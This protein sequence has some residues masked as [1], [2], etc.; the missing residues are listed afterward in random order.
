MINDNSGLLTASSRPASPAPGGIESNF[1]GLELE[2][3]SITDIGKFLRH[4]G[5]TIGWGSELTYLPDRN[6]TAS[7]LVSQPT[8]TGASALEDSGSIAISK[9]IWSTVQQYPS[10]GSAV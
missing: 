7:V 9:N 8:P 2:S 1:Y 4:N 6:I 3:D 5:A 10:T